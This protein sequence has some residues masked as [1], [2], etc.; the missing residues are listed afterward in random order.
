MP[1]VYL[2]LA[3][4]ALAIALKTTSSALAI[5]CLL[6][7]LVLL[8]FWVL[9]L[10][11]SRVEAGSRDASMIV[12]PMELKRLREQAEARRLAQSAGR[13]ASSSAPSAE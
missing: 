12:D 6:A 5:A 3:L 8:L 7:A 13:D 11:A 9:G 4:G 1:W 10:L 2:L